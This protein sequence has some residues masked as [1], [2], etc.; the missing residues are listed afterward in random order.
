M[1]EG[2]FDVAVVG[3]GLL[4]GAAGAALARSGQSVLLLEAR[5][6]GHDFGSSHG[7]SRIIRTLAAETPVFAA[8]AQDAF[9]QMRRLESA[10]GPVVRS[11]EAIFVTTRDS[12]AHRRIMQQHPYAQYGRDELRGLGLMIDDS[13]VGVL[14]PTSGVFDPEALLDLLYHRITEAGCTIRFETGVI[15]WQ[16][17]E[18][19]VS[20][21][22]DDGRTV[23]ARKL[24]LSAGAWLP[25][26]LERGP[27]PAAVK[28]G[29]RMR[30]ERIPLFYF[31]YPDGMKPLIPVTLFDSGEP[32]MYA[33]PEFHSREDDKPRYLKAGFHKGTSAERPDEACRTV[34]HLEIRYATNCLEVLLGRR[35]TLRH[36]SVCLYAMAGDEDLPLIGFLPGVPSVY[37][38][39]YGGGVCAKH[40]LAL[41]RAAS[42][43]LQGEES[44]WDLSP[45]RPARLLSAP[46]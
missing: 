36:T 28:Q 29:M 6:K 30:L 21:Q 17:G 31:D 35:L 32:D 25:E 23:R 39:A 34:Q 43:E 8:M 14:D 42:C 3:G 4:G 40:A 11:V 24:V 33:M 41:G 2:H 46:L 44:L 1:A 12:V 19:G 15:S 27:V 7:R 45:F 16:A 13:K 38:A 5:K 26:L 18:S 9:E 37:L 22:C 20:L 10:N